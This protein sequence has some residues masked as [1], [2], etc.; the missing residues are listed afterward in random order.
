MWELDRKEGWGPK[1]WCFW[2]VVLEKTLESPLGSKKIKP[3]NPKRN[4]PWIFFGRTDAEAYVKSRFMG[5]TLILGKIKGGRRR[6]Q[7]RMR[8]LDGIMDSMEINLSKLWKIVKDKE[9]LC[10]AVHGVM[11]SWI[12]LTDWTKNPCSLEWN[13]EEIFLSRIISM[14]FRSSCSQKQH[15]DISSKDLNFHTGLSYLCPYVGKKTMNLICAIPCLE[16]CC[17]TQLFLK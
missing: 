10:V 11:K 16:T 1:N 7:Q 4:Q 14:T 17:R 9:D 2:I 6:G 8:W 13:F 3:V 5:N 15:H 12:W